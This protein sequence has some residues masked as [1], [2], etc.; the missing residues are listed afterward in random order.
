MTKKFF[1]IKKVQIFCCL[2]KDGS[3]KFH[4]FYN[5]SLDERIENVVVW[6][7]GLT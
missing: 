7:L 4:Q 6:R 5:W 2:E 3:I 1:L